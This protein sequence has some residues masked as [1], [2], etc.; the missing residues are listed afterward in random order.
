MAL[1]SKQFQFTRPQAITLTAGMLQLTFGCFDIFGL[2]P[3]YH[4]VQIGVGVLGVVMAWRLHHARIYGALLLLAFGTLA[5]SLNELT[6]E[7]FLEVRTAF[8]GLMIML[9]RP[10]KVARR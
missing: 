8:L 5:F 2:D 4:V 6:T 1:S 7:A 10:G 3:N 9:V